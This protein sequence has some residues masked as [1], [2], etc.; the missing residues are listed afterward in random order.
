ME[1]ISVLGQARFHYRHGGR[2]ENGFVA[3]DGNMREYNFEQDGNTTHDAKFLQRTYLVSV[4]M[5][6]EDMQLLD[7]GSLLIMLALEQNNG[8]Q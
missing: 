3:A 1:K 7:D 2:A 5:F 4:I 8:Q 6:A